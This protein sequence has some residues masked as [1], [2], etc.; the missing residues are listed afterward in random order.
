MITD[1]IFHWLNLT[2]KGPL[3]PCRDLSAECRKQWFDKYS[4][5]L[6]LIISIYQVIRQREKTAILCWRILK[7]KRKD[8][9]F[10]IRPRSSIYSEIAREEL[11]C[12]YTINAKEACILSGRD[13]PDD[14]ALELC[15]R[16]GNPAVITDGAKGAYL[17]CDNKVSLIPGVSIKVA[18]TIGSGDAHTGGFIAG[19][20][21]D[22]S[23]QDAVKLANYT[24]SLCNCA[25]GSSLCS[26]SGSDVV[27]FY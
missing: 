11:N 8:S 22:L 2:V 27:F 25:S 20:M 10:N 12:I 17:A 6:I 15:K 13:Y 19:L 5:S 24:A 1:G 18:D 4:F 16:T 9:F 23:L 14:A 7:R 3:L 21:C 26:D